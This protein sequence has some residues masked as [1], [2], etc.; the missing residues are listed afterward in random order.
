MKNNIGLIISREYTLRVKKKGFIV[1]TLVMPVFFL[2][3]MFAP[4]LIQSLGEDDFQAVTVVDDSGVMMAPLS[5]E[6]RMPY[7]FVNDVALD[8][9]LTDTDREVVLHLGAD[10]I[11]NPADVTLY[12]HDGGSVKLEMA[13]ADD[14][15][16]AV[17]TVRLQRY[18]IPGLDEIIAQ[19]DAQVK[20]TTK[21]IGDD[22]Q[23]TTSDTVTS[24]LVGMAMAFILYIFIIVYG[25]LVMMSIIEEKNNRVLEIIVTSIKPAQ[26]MIGKI[27][28]V[29]AVAVTQVMIWGVLIAAFISFV[30]PEIM[31]P[32]LGVEIE[33]FR[34]GTL[35]LATA[36]TDLSLLQT[37]AMLSSLSYIFSIFGYL[38][39]FLIGGFLL[40]ASVYAAIGSAVDN[41]QDGAQ[42]QM[43]AILPVIVGLIFAMSVGQ[44]PNSSLAYWLSIIPFTSPMV[45]MARIPAGVPVGELILS[46][47]LLYATIVVV[48]WFTA[49]IYRVG[50]FMYGKKPTIKEI[51]R[52][53]RYK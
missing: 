17:E 49:K 9:L 23:T 1:T 20:I 26:L 7:A 19:I 21:T 39:L 27:V 48:I 46:L 31:G 41:A 40:Y 30:L 10:I 3:L 22:G 34:N 18:D 28:G 11:D 12:T 4:A 47:V 32:Q 24:L 25:Q 5:Q 29:G 38:V 53:S 51:I 16:R 6:A 36:T 33:A 15:K 8:S 50:I 35:D 2:L 43:F 37:L 13:I 52:W 42:L 14:L 45:M 44:D